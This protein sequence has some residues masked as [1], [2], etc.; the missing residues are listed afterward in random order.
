MHIYKYYIYTYIH[1][2]CVYTYMN[3][4]LLDPASL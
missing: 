4:D 1:Y 2:I 3:I